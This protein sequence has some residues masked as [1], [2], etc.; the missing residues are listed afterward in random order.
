M[1]RH[2]RTKTPFLAIA[3]SM[4]K[5][6]APGNRSAAYGCRSRSPAG[7]AGN[8][9]FPPPP[10]RLQTQREAGKLEI[11][12]DSAAIYHNKSNKLPLP[13]L[14]QCGKI[15]TVNILS[16]LTDRFAL[17]H[18]WGDESIPGAWSA[19][20]PAERSANANHC[21]G[22]AQGVTSTDSGTM[23]LSLNSSHGGRWRQAEYKKMCVTHSCPMPGSETL[24]A[25]VTW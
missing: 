2:G 5:G 10:G 13:S 20:L 19:A 16:S 21:R 22:P 14:P 1:C 25:A 9:P 17:N 3:E 6:C 24:P 23:R 15:E 8:R 7:P 18:E 11:Q 12:N 4:E